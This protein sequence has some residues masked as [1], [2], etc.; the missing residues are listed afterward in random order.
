MPW[1]QWRL[2]L[3]G[4]GKY[5]SHSQEQYPVLKE[6]SNQGLAKRVGRLSKI[7]EVSGR[8]VGM[9]VVK[10]NIEKLSGH[11]DIQ[12]IKEKGTSIKIHLPLTMANV[13]GMILPVGDERYIIPT[14]K[15][16]ES[17][18]PTRKMVNTVQGKG[19]MVMLR[20]K[21]VPILRLARIFNRKV[22]EIKPWESLLVVVS[23]ENKRAG[24]M[25]DSLLGQQQVVIKNLGEHLHGIQGVSGGCILGDGR[26][27]L[28]PDVGGLIAMAEHYCSY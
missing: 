26:V 2:I 25:V 4:M 23:S 19:E 11:L 20:G 6:A 27:A 13:D 17:L 7:T 8:G 15:I 3:P 10:R 24:L 22:S 5:A 1:K 14:L 9:D 18:R 12:S 21:L 28:I 16:E